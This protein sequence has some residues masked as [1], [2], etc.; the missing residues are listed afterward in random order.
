[1][2]VLSNA[3]SIADLSGKPIRWLIIDEEKDFLPGRV[4]YAL[5]RTRSK[6]DLKIW[7]MSTSK[8][9]EDSIHLAF[10]GGSQDCWHVKCPRCGHSEQV[11]WKNFRY[12]AKGLVLESICLTCPAPVGIDG[13]NQP[14]L[15]GY[16][17]WDRPEDRLYI[18]DQGHYVSHN[19]GAPYPS[20]SF[21]G[22]VAPWISWHSIGQD[23]LLAMEAKNKGDFEPFRRFLCD[24]ANEP[25]VEQPVEKVPEVVRFPYKLDDYKAA[26]ILSEAFRGMGVD[27]QLRDFRVVIRAW[28]SDASSKLLCA[29]AVTTFDDLRALQIEYAIDDRFCFLDSAFQSEIV[30]SKCAEF[31]WIAIVGSDE[32]SFNHPKKDL[33]GKTIG[34][35]QKPFSS[36]REVWS[37]KR[38]ANCR[39]ITL[40]TPRLKD[41]T[42]FLRDGRGTVSWEVPSDTPSDYISQV[43][44]Q[45]RVERI[46]ETTKRM[47]MVWPDRK[48]DHAWDAEIMCTAQ[49]IIA[50]ILKL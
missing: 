35:I 14:I 18:L 3:G 8:K 22:A 33:H 23:W 37:F 24:T 32:Y 39:Q 26:K 36:F 49:A 13:K 19:P 41:L 34:Y 10:L 11:R 30:Y 25:W 4:E 21:W 29:K 15:C 31:G 45:C 46:N 12:V 47:E 48:S 5:A 38:G 1:M 50:G 20:W 16:E 7:R 43:Y 2:F 27:V 42:S 28:A 44:S 40:A 17:W 9:S 6:R